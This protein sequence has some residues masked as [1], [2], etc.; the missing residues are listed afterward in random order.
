[1]SAIEKIHFREVIRPL[2]TTFSTSLGQKHFMKSVIV[3][4]VLEDGSSGL[5]ECP[6]S[7][8][9]KEETVYRPLKALFAKLCQS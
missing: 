4:V 8:V 1:M 7:F 9:L 2:R 6:T 5:G 3:K